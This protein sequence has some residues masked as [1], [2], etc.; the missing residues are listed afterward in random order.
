M[1][2]LYHMAVRLKDYITKEYC[3]IIK[4]S[5]KNGVLKLNYLCNYWT[6]N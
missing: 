4:N 5:K 2:C 6:D 3:T 1:P